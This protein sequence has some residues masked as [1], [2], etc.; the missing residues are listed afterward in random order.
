M[1]ATQ[2]LHSGK[3]VPASKDRSADRDFTLFTNSAFDPPYDTFTRRMSE[4]I[5][6][7]PLDPAPQFVVQTK[8]ALSTPTL[9]RHRRTLTPD[10]GELGPE[11]QAALEAEI[12]ARRAAR[13]AS[14]R[15]HYQC[16]D[17]NDDNRVLIGTRVAEGHQNYQLM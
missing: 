16:D 13:R 10:L 7:F 6:P 1:P 11:E 17:E 15:M 9:S 5:A 4:D 12:T 2:S 8:R 14:R 3:S